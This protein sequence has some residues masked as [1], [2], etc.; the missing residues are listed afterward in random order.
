M[1]TSYLF[2]SKIIWIIVLGFLEFIFPDSFEA[3]FD[4]IQELTGCVGRE[5]EEELE[6]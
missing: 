5:Y 1:N 6:G 3:T 2:C 4:G